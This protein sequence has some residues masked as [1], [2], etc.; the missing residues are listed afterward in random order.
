MVIGGPTGTGKSEIASRVARLVQGEIISAD[1]RQFYREITV[2][3]D[4]APDWMRK[5]IPHHLIDFLSLHDTFN[6]ADYSRKAL[7]VVRETL[8]RGRVP[9]LV[10][11]SGLYLRS[12]LQGVFQ[13]D[14]TDKSGQPEIRQ[15]LERKTTD[16]LYQ[17]LKAVDPEICAR[18]HPHDRRRIRRALEVYYLIGQP[19]SVCQKG[20]PSGTLSDLGR[21]S[22]FILTRPRKA[23]YERIERRVDEMFGQGWIKEVGQ[24]KPAYEADLREKA[25]IGYREILD[26]LDGRTT[27]E[28]TRALVKQRTRNLAKRQLTWFRK[29][30]GTWLEIPNDNEERIVDR[31]VLS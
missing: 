24:L 23:L 15:E 4:K 18:I 6:I 1:S 27:L 3:T 29:E 30:P 20:K 19:M 5:E 17:E 2:G 13:A 26:Y 9:I 10:G 16:V 7:Q 12:L 21:V 31:I 28:E 14:E 25:P 11:G 8:T 22:Y